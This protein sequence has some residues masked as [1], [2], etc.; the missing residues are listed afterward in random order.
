MGYKEPADS[1]RGV[2]GLPPRV[3]TQPLRQQLV[4]AVLRIP[5]A[6]SFEGRTAFLLGLPASL[7]RNAPNARADLDAVFVQLDGLGRLDSS[8]WPLLAAIDC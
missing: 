1:T 7:S 3:L 2:S 5:A 4:D 6:D 8:Q